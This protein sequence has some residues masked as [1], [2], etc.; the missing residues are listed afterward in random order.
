MTKL[1]TLRK[2]RWW[3]IAASLLLTGALVPLY[4]GSRRVDEWVRQMEGDDG[5]CL[6][7]WPPTPDLSATGWTTV[8]L[9]IPAAVFLIAG[10]VLI[11]IGPQRR[12]VKLTAT[13]V[14]SCVLLASLFVLLIGYSD[15]TTGVDR[16]TVSGSDGGPLCAFP[17][18]QENR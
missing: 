16:Y 17:G 12:W 8:G 4:V 15:A 11:V 10:L 3:F 7:P 2:A 9:V 5:R 6:P 13:A 1:G 14:G 18:Q